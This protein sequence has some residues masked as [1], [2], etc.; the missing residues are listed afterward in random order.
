MMINFKL[1]L[2]MIIAISHIFAANFYLEINISYQKLTL[3]VKK[4]ITKLL[5]NSMILANFKA[6]SSVFKKIN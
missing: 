6:L 1:L 2:V 5:Y 4:K 3:K